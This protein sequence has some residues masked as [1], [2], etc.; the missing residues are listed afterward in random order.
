MTTNANQHQPYSHLAVIG[1]GAW[2]TAL[3]I[4]ASEAGRR[5]TL[6]TRDPGLARTMHEGGE[7]SRHLPAIR[8]PAGIRVTA[9]L[10]A[11]QGVDAALIVTPAQSLWHVLGSLSPHLAAGTPV[12]LCAKGIEV[13]TGRLLTEAAAEVAPDLA[14]AILSGP[15]FARDVARG[16]PTAVAVAGTLPVARRL[17]AT[18]A[19]P[20]FRPYATDDL[21]GVAL[22]G[23]AKNV[24]AIACGMTEGLGLGESAR[25]AL[26]ARGFAELLRL[27]AALGA[28]SETLMG[29]A[30]LGDL[31]LSATSRTS[32]NFDLGWRIASGEAAFRPGAPLAEGAST[33]GAILARAAE[34]GVELPIGAAVHAILSGRL[35]AREGV[36]SLLARPLR[37][38]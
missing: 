22:G 28:R 8:L 36:E 2:G 25:A 24:Y 30:G 3:A 12:V 11:C 23:A 18:L 34:E 19:R 26:L 6:W 9:D 17:Q 10:A 1:A 27:G 29:L 5:V 15:S 7:N 32:R 13:G 31:A 14:I 4:A 16:L 21:V 20:V 33:A 38:E 35:A 37:D